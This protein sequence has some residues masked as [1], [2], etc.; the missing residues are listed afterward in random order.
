MTPGNAHR[1]T[2][3]SVNERRERLLNFLKTKVWPAVPK[4]EL[5]RRLD[6]AEE[7][8]ILGYGPERADD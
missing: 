5:G 8:A 7:D 6:R 3:A 4:K 1:L 2:G